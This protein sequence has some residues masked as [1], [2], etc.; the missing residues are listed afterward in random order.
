MRVR[1]PAAVLL[2][3]AALAAPP[4]AGARTGAG[5]TVLSSRHLWATVNV[6]DGPRH[7]NTMGLR[8]SM[9][10]SG[11]RRER[12]FMRFQAQYLAAADGRW[13]NVARGGDSG[14]RYVGRAVFKARQAGWLFVF[15]APA[16]SPL[17]LRGAVT[18][19]WR[20]GRRVVRRARMATS[21]G[22]RS[23]AGSDPA[24]YSADT[25]VIA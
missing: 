8:G 22:H 6:C 21:A 23:A 4:S 5:P 25:C 11:N 9:P 12:M 24:G 20:V 10:G 19:E 3:A 15:P 1:V 17:R 18:F 13:H 7:P 14:F 2:A 16:G